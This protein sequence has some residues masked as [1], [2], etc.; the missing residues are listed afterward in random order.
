MSSTIHASDSST[1][2]S[3]RV[4]T[5][6]RGGGAAG[7]SA[8]VARITGPDAKFGL[9]REFVDADR[10]GLSRSG[11]SGTIIWPVAE[12]VYEFRG[13]SAS[14][15][16][17]TS[18]FFRVTGD[19]VEMVDRDEVLARLDEIAAEAEV[20]D[21]AHRDE[22]R[23]LSQ[24]RFG[25]DVI[26]AAGGV[27]TSRHG[28]TVRL[29]VEDLDAGLP[30]EDLATVT[31]TARDW[32]GQWSAIVGNNLA[33]DT[34]AQRVLEAN[35][36]DVRGQGPGGVFYRWAQRTGPKTLEQRDKAW[37]G[38]HRLVYA[39]AGLDVTREVAE[40]LASAGIDPTEAAGLVAE[41]GIEQ[42]LETAMSLGSLRRTAA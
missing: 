24:P 2:T 21:K 27:S 7:G 35:V 14:S 18:G 19:Q 33:P 13:L 3:T 4:S 31:I 11:G 23:R 10:S 15:R 37:Q 17:T 32:A 34:Q 29:T 41:H 39:L 22:V 26:P 25:A 6:V 30:W 42:V 38:I 12:G 8:W 36:P 28:W 9:A 40:T 16:H 5:R 20:I 1:I